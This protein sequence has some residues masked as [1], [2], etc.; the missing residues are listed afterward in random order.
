M[1][2]VAATSDTHG[3]LVELQKAHEE[4]L[5]GDIFIHAGDFTA[6]NKRDHFG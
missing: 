6:Y 4:G 1:V 2:K 3:N 5:T